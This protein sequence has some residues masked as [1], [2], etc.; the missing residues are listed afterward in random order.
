MKHVENLYD[1]DFHREI[2]DNHCVHGG[3]LGFHRVI[4]SVVFSNEY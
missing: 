1:T 4:L 2:N 3:S